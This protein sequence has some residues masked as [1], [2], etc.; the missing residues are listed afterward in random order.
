MFTS[1]SALVSLAL[2]YTSPVM[3][4][5]A[6]AS[7]STSVSADMPSATTVRLAAT[8]PSLLDQNSRSVSAKSA[9][10][11][12]AIAP[13]KPC[14]FSMSKSASELTAL[15]V[16]VML[17]PTLPNPKTV[18]PSIEPPSPSL[19]SPSAIAYTSLATTEMSPLMATPA[20]SMSNSESALS[21]LAITAM[22]RMVTP[23]FSVSSSNLAVLLMEPSVFGSTLDATNSLPLKPNTP[24]S[25]GRTV[26]QMANKP[27]WFSNA[28]EPSKT[29]AK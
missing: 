16:T 20:P 9:P 21:A 8:K 28:L 23:S 10:D 18:G 24:V 22:L 4:K 12:T 26:S 5:S 14:A 2:T 3:V 17:L 25:C 19:M 29:S 11:V 7:I 1:A 15:A 13:T 27:D 6:S